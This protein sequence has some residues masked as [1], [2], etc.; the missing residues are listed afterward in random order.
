MAS[1]MDDLKAGEIWTGGVYGTLNSL[2]RIL[3]RPEFRAGRV[4]AFF[5]AGVPVFRKKLVPGYKQERKEKKELLTE[6][7]KDKAFEQLLTSRDLLATLGVTSVAFK[8]YE[9]DD[10]VA[11][12]S[13]Y[14]CARDI[15][16]VVVTGDR[17]L[18]QCVDDGASVWYLNKGGVYVTPDTFA[19]EVGGIYGCDPVCASQYLLF[20]ALM[21]DK[22]DG[23]PG[24]PGCGK[25]RAASLLAE[26][27]LPG[28]GEDQ[29]AALIKAVSAKSKRR[30]FEDALITQQDYLSKVLRVFDLRGTFPEKTIAK[31]LGRPAEVDT[32][33]FLS[34]CKRLQFASVLGNP[35]KYI[36]PFSVALERHNGKK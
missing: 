4:Y 11:A 35:E 36:R 14:F 32:R 30:K 28:T 17:D 29:L 25:G 22:S 15:F 7:Q 10:L 20:K 6:E 19:T 9:A 12:A 26:Y 34:Q 13:R 31:V 3:T 8:D 5:D 18:F 16:P 33:A 1:A 23:V 21:G 2:V 27:D 24:V